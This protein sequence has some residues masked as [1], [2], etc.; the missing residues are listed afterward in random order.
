MENLS[1]DCQD[2]PNEH[3]NKPRIV[4]YGFFSEEK[5]LY[6][7]ESQKTQKKML[8]KSLASNAWAGIFKNAD[9]SKNSSK[10]AKLSKF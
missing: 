9:F 10:N 7:N 2:R 8:R 5:V 3:E 1:N 6:E 4:S